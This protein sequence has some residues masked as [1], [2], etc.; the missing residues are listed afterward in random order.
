MTSIL[1]QNTVVFRPP[2]TLY[3][4]YRPDHPVRYSPILSSVRTSSNSRLGE[5]KQADLPSGKSAYSRP[6]LS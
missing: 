4:L 1:K 3:S 5:K 6:A 2:V